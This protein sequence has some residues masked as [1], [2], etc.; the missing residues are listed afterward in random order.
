MADRL[1]DNP[2]FYDNANYFIEYFGWLTQIV[3]LSFIIGVFTD[4]PNGFLAVNF[5]IKVLFALYLI[6]RFNSYRKHK[7][8]FTDLDRKICFSA[9]IY[10]FVFSFIDVIQTYIE[11]LRDIIDPY[12][13][14]ILNQVKSMIGMTPSQYHVQK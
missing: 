11:Q 10:I 12:T 9:G 2:L 4:K 7:I 3:L 8:Q 14:P 5:F 13:V 1:V 6:Y